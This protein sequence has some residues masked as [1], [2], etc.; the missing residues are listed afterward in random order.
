MSRRR[1]PAVAP[2]R[3]STGAT[4]VAGGDPMA[5][6]LAEVTMSSTDASGER[7]EEGRDSFATEGPIVVHVWDV[8]PGQ[9]RVAVGHLDDMLRE[10][11][12][13][14]GLVAGRVL[15]SDDRLSLAALLEMRSVE[16][17]KRLEQLPHV[18]DTL[19][20]LPGTVNIVVRL[21]RQVAA[22][23]AE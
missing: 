20:R 15:A 9:E 23:P 3:D 13:D 6:N 12:S 17:R 22:Y 1:P 14:P 19:E 5:P 11:E 7:A 4:P 21:Y 8:E 16:D 18:R 10:I 2:A